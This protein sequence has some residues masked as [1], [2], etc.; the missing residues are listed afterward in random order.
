MIPQIKKI[1][2]LCTILVLTA[3]AGEK[4]AGSLVNSPVKSPIP[5]FLPRTQE[6]NMLPREMVGVDFFSI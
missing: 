2:L 1:F 6:E 5:Y 4:S 3:Q